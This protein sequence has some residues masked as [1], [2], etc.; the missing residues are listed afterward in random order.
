MRGLAEEFGRRLIVTDRFAVAV[1]S[2]LRKRGV[3]LAKELGLRMQT[4]LNEQIAEK[5][6]VEEVLYKEYA[7]YTDVYLRD[8]LLEREAIVAHCIWM[9]GGEFDVV[10]HSGAVIA[11][12]PTSNTLL[13]SGVMPLDEV[14]ARE[15]P[16][17]ICTDVGAS[18]TTSI[19]AE[20]AEYL[21]V[22]AGRSTGATPS[23]ALYRSTLAPAKMLGLEDRVGSFEVGKPL[24]F[25]EVR[26]GSEAMRSADEVIQR[27]LL[28]ISPRELDDYRSGERGAA[29]GALRDKGLDLSGQLA[30]LEADVRETAR[31]LDG[32]VLSVTI[33]GE[34]V[35]RAS[36]NG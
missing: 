34:E 35:W 15:I 16:Y 18:P 31:R 32:K 25:I 17:A 36:G 28:E 33:G 26:S 29:T 5:K 7:S 19:L 9:N 2:G 4:H 24:S 3:A 12:C 22:H 21:K 23:E 10:K 1:D 14:M 20:M 30:L 8:G 6:F 11:H 13:G 27:G